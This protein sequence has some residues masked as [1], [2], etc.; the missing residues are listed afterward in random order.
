MVLA[1]DPAIGHGAFNQDLLGP[2][3]RFFVNLGD[4][5]L[6]KI[7]GVYPNPTVDYIKIQGVNLAN[8]GLTLFSMDGKEFPLTQFIESWNNGLDIFE[9]NLRD[10]P[11]G[12]YILKISNA[13]DGIK[14]VKAN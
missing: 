10:I 11:A 8:N 7:I 4:Q 3:S 13:A 2:C 12:T 14:V 1:N 5:K 6:P 9:I